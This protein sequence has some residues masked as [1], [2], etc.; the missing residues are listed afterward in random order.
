MKKNVASQII[1]CQMITAA[2]GTA[3]TGTVTAYFTLDGGSQ[4][5]GSVGSGVC[6][7]EG[8]GF[9]TYAPAQ[10]ETNGDHVAFTFIGTGAINS[11][12]QVYPS[13]PQTVDN[14][15]LA[16][17]AT[18][19]AAINTDVEAILADTNELQGDWA[20]AGRLDTIL[21]TIAE[22][23]TTDIPALI[24]DVPTVAEFNARTLPSAD[25]VVTTDTI[26]GVTLVDTVTDVTNEVTAD[27]TKIS[28]SAA[29]ANNLEASALT[30]LS[31]YTAVTGTLS[32]TQMTTDLT[33]VTDDHYNGRIIIWT[34]GVLQNQATNIT[35][36]D[37]ASKMLT[38]TAT[39]EAPSNLD[40]FVIV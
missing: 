38:F 7:H 40:T 24:A 39:T 12:V 20:N 19:F 14:N 29:A 22:D 5:I 37:G 15:V 31:T 26:A 2:D 9:H 17:G 34:S 27:V 18:G 8:N 11:T 33:E 21:D 30:I 3:F 23:T 32:T 25:Y 35:D 28:G 10:A 4:T 13:F 1:G 16:A 6:T 36:Y